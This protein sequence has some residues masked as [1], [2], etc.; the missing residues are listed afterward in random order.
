MLTIG[1]RSDSHYVK[2]PVTGRGVSVSSMK[3]NGAPV[4]LKGETRRYMA[5]SVT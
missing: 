5:L 4:M 3:L 2:E 1:G